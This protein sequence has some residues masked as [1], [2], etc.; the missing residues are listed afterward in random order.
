MGGTQIRAGIVV[1]NDI[2]SIAA[3][4]I[5][6]LGTAEEILED[7]FRFTDP[8]IN[9]SVTAIGIGVPGLANAA[10]SVVYD[11]YNIPAWTEMHL[12]QLL[13]DR[14]HVPVLVNNDANC[15]A[16]GEY[17]FGKGK[18]HDSMIGLTIGTGL[19]SGII[20]NHQ[21]YAGENGGAGEFGMM[22]YLDKYY[23]YYACGQFFDNIYGVSGEA[24]FERAKNGDAEAKRMY[25]E[26]GFHLGKAIRSILYAFDVGLI[27][28]GGSVRHAYPFFSKPMW[29][30]INGLIFRK[31]K[32]KLKIEISELS[33]S[34]IFGAA[35]LHLKS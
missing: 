3:Q 2:S 16:L 27:V 10:Q 24:V 7:V 33:N 8:L 4:K 26:M 34:G 5:N 31:A 23:E 28:L 13:Q 29:E 14:Y 32:E 35:A 22:D 1:D 25:E 30:L 19:G 9:T 15:F 6:P 11:V 18:G 17:H 20:L 21:L 12:Q